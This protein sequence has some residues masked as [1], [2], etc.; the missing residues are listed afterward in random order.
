MAEKTEKLVVSDYYKSLSE[1]GKKKFREQLMEEFGISFPT[2]YYKLRN[3]SWR[4]YEIKYITEYIEK[5]G[6]I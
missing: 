5:N 2:V 4:L 1:E 3:E 6:I